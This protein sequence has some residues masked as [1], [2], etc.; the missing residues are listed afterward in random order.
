MNWMDRGTDIQKMIKFLKYIVDTNGDC[1]F[2]QCVLCPF[3]I[4]EKEGYP[5]HCE[6]SITG[7]YKEKIENAKRKIAEFTA[8]EAY[9]K[10]NKIL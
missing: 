8:R 10:K 1:T 7:N 9:D 2:N 3:F 4:T 5:K 6:L